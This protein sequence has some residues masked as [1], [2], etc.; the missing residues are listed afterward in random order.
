MDEEEYKFQKIVA[1]YQVV[2]TMFVAMGTI[3]VAFGIVFSVPPNAND[4]GLCLMYV[5]IVIVGAGGM[6]CGLAILKLKVRT[7]VTDSSK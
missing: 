4:V 7:K 3:V 1:F 5:G 2:A 6:G